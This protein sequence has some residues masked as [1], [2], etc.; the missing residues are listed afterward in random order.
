VNCCL[1]FC[2]HFAVRFIPFRCC[3][4][5]FA[6]D[7]NQWRCTQV[8]SVSSCSPQFFFN[9]LLSQV[10]GWDT[11]IVALAN[12]LHQHSILKQRNNTLMKDDAY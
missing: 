9:L 10:K 3:F 6:K 7:E 5:G 4:S 11:M 2:L 1:L 8:V 12:Q